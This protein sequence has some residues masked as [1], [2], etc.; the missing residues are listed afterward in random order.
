MNLSNRIYSRKV[1]YRLIY[2]Y[3][4]FKSILS[5]NIYINFAEKIDNIVHQWL[6]KI[7]ISA[8]EKFD[9][10]KLLLVKRKYNSTLLTIQDYLSSFDPKN[11]EKFNEIVTYTANFFVSNKQNSS[12]EYQYLVNNMNYLL[13]NYLNIV[14][15]IDKYLDTFKFF[16]LNS[17]DQS[18]LLLG[19]VENRTVNTPKSVIIK[20]CLFLW[21]SFTSDSS[22]KLINAVLDKVIKE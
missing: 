10:S 2:M 19:I 16:E 12:L 6:D 21:S 9:F 7:D 8:F 11:E 5:K 18:I 1:L 17:V 4:F 20:E 15:E 14:E 3:N 22:I 13:E